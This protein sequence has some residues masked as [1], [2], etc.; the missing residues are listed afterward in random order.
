M[1]KYFD[2][3]RPF[4]KRVVVGVGLTLFILLNFWFV[5]PYFSELS[6]LRS[7]LAEARDQKEE[8]EKLIAII[9]DYQAKIKALGGEGAT[10]VP[11][12]ERKGEFQTLITTEQ[13]KS[14]LNLVNMGRGGTDTNN[15]Y[16]VELSQ[17]I[18]VQGSETNL[19]AFLYNLGAGSSMIY[20]KGLAVQPD[21]PTRYNLSARV[22]LVASYQ[23]APGKAG[24]GLSARKAAA[25]SA[26]AKSE[27]LPNL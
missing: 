8:Y 14:G 22:T 17:P 23:K 25:K 7:R 3:L 1:K 21:A 6:N 2:T 10:N 20:V 18:T 26:K 24:S 15:T 5:F 4:E 12:E 9:P 13:M 11:P 16:F 19:V 27:D